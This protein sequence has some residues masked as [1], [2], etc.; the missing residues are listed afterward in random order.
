VAD[1]ILHARLIARPD[2]QN[3]KDGVIVSENITECAASGAA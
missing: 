2:R 1:G 3:I